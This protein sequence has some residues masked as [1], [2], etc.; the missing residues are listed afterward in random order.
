[1]DNEICPRINSHPKVLVSDK[2][3]PIATKIKG[4]N[5]CKNPIKL[6]GLNSFIGLGLLIVVFFLYVFH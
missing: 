3:S 6:L 5:K 4:E 2:W 1:M